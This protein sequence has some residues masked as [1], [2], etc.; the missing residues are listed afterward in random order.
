MTPHEFD[1]DYVV[2]GGGSGG[3]ASAKRA[4]QLYGARVAV[5][6]KS[7][8]GGTCVNVGCVPKKV[9]FNAATQAHFLAHEAQH[10][11]FSGSREVANSFDWAKV[12]NARDAY[13]KRLN[14]IYE[15]GLRN[16]NIDIVRGTAAFRDEHTL[17]V[18][19][20]DKT[21][22]H[23]TAKYILIATGGRPIFP[24]G[25]GIEDNCISS[26][27]FFELEERPETVCIVGAGY[28][29]VE[30]AGVLNSLGSEVHL[31]IRKGNALRNFDEIV[32][33]GLDEEMVRSGIRI[34]RFSGGVAK[35]T[36]AN[37]KKTITTHSGD[38]IYGVD[39]VIV[40][41]GRAPNVEGLF[42]DKAKVLLTHKG[43]IQVDKHQKTTSPSIFA[44]GDVCGRVELTPMAIAAGR[45]L[46]DRLLGNLA[47][48]KVSYET[49]PSVVFSHPPIGTIGLTEEQA[50][51]KYGQDNLKLYKSSFAN[52][53]YGIFDVNS[54][55]KPQ[56]RMKLICAGDDELVVG[57]HCIGMGVDEMMQGF[58]I[59]M[60]MGATKAD[61]DNTIAIHPTASEELVTMGTWGTST[62]ITGAK[63][64]TLNG[65][66]GAG[67]KLK[68]KM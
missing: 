60:R 55:D 26:D 65:E 4:S 24:E 58:G 31:V 51:A 39:C 7:R 56:T 12:K 23:L 14:G 42:L 15:A 30:L 48:A 49:V 41:P 59:A 19:T 2:I 53:F 1:Y 50:V 21:F 44:L 35:I 5:I 38:M 33:N 37:G 43:Y 11:G 10:Y 32:M 18:T 68:S 54:A 46:A 40:A 36:N 67:P 17:A 64:N 16:A 34:H 62:L 8:L 25:E 27:G 6:E 57:I 9:M 52:L 63:A 61:F 3:I 45:R 29:A 47:N 28:I 22:T 13:V 66:A 20:D